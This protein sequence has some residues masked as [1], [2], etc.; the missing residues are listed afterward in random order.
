MPGNSHPASPR[1]RVNSSGGGVFF[2]LKD[3]TGCCFRRM[4]TTKMAPI[5]TS[6]QTGLPGQQPRQAAMAGTPLAFRPSSSPLRV[7]AQP[8]QRWNTI[9]PET[10]RKPR[11]PRSPQSIFFYR[12]TIV[13]LGS[14]FQLF[15]SWLSNRFG[16]LVQ[17]SI[18][19]QLDMSRIKNFGPQM[20]KNPSN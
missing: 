12:Y 6:A 7:K 3:S 18:F 19:C 14:F 1:L 13:I 16:F 4:I 8:W 20:T 9:N 10:R 2:T 5:F 15:P 17:N 11:K